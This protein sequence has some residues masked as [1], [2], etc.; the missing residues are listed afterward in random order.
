[1]VKIYIQ[2]GR[3]VLFNRREIKPGHLLSA[4]GYE[5]SQGTL[6]G[7]VIRINN[8]VKNVAVTD[9][10]CELGDLDGRELHFETEARPAAS[11]LYFHYL[12]P[13]LRA[14]KDGRKG[15]LSSPPWRAASSVGNPAGFPPKLFQRFFSTIP[16]P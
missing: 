1:L 2:I 15:L 10:D 8:S 4:Q 16:V 11:Y 6:G 7:P 5:Q 12:L 13:T 9:M 14:R 3:P